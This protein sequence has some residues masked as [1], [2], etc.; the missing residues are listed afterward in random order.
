[1][2]DT[3]TNTH[4][5]IIRLDPNTGSFTA[6]SDSDRVATESPLEI[7]VEGKSIA[8]VMRTPGNDEELTAGFLLTENI[9]HKKSDIFELSQCPSVQPSDDNPESNVIEVV[10]SN[11]EQANLDQLTRHVFS[12]SS[13]GICGKATIDSVFQSF[14]PVDKDNLAISASTLLSLPEKL[15]AAQDTFNETGGLHASALF[16]PQGS[17][18]TLREDVGRHNALDKILGHALLQNQLPLSNKILLVSG[19]I[20]FE[21]AQKA[22]AAK[23]SVIAG[24]SAPSSLAVDFC[25]RSNQTLV[26]FLRELSMNVYTHPERV[27]S[28]S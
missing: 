17:L 20:S 24:I 23:I 4:R 25:N 6:E 28:A 3:S 26:G 2:T 1:M 21:L 14:P 18:L 19:R 27:L 11:P 12:S 7:R 13:C 10:L 22:L 8:V 9:V 5:R 15:R 16:D